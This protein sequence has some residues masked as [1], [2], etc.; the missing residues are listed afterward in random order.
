MKNKLFIKKLTAVS[1]IVVICLLTAMFYFPISIRLDPDFGWHLLLGKNM[2]ESG[3]LIKSFI[4]YNNIFG[5]IPVIDHQWLSDI[6]LYLA[7]QKW[8][9]VSLIAASFVVITATFS[10]VYYILRRNGASALKSLVFVLLL[11]LPIGMILYG[12][13]IQYL[14]LLTVALILMVRNVIKPYWARVLVYFIIF[15]VGV[16]FHGGGMMVLIIIPILLECENLSLKK[17]EF[18]QFLK[19]KTLKLLALTLLLLLSMI[20]TPNGMNL[21]YLMWQYITS[22]YY[23]TH[24]S[25]WLPIY[26]Y[27]F[28]WGNIILPLS[29]FIFI[30]ISGKYWKRLKLNEI[31]LISIFFLLSLKARRTFPI[32]AIIFLSYGYL[33]KTELSFKLNKIF[34]LLLSTC[35]VLLMLAKSVENTLIFYSK[36]TGAPY[37]D[38]SYPKGAS[39]Y[40]RSK[41]LYGGKMLNPYGWGGYLSWTVQDLKL[42]VD[43]RSPQTPAKED[44]S[45]LEVYENFYND[46]DK[47]IEGMLKS[48]NIEYVLIDK[49][50]KSKLRWVDKFALEYDQSLINKIENP[51]NNLLDYLEDNADSWAVVYEDEISKIYQRKQ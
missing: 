19:T 50:K 11:F 8:G 29:F 32:F 25:E 27:P 18:I 15:S 43:G 2:V 46:D 34:A 41:S 14:L 44:K 26:Y 33:Y 4:G 39:E 3:S 37:N 36:I 12:T 49:P 13:R 42:T 47:I 40:I 7:Y 1:P 16:N 35:I 17:S 51:T 30:F 21:F 6:L 45:I 38:E 48:N 24:I 22:T 9:Y 5:S 31:V 10:I 23:Q 28:L 20:L